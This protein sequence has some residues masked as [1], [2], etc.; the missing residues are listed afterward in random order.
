[1]LR[2]QQIMNR[3]A[4]ELNDELD[5]YIT[6]F[7]GC[8]FWRI[9]EG[10]LIVNKTFKRIVSIIADYNLTTVDFVLDNVYELPESSEFMMQLLARLAFQYG[11]KGG[12][13]I[14]NRSMV[15]CYLLYYITTIEGDL[16][17]TDI[18]KDSANSELM[19]KKESL[20]QSIKHAIGV[21]EYPY[22]VKGNS[23]AM[24]LMAIVSGKP[25]HETMR[26][27]AEYK[28]LM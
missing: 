6:T 14:L 13:S 19:Y 12:E 9:K 24:G 21:S 25:I 8:D 2:E 17:A 5:D 20:W 15:L 22:K 16:K 28:D 4:S 3:I 27:I 1:M 7:N 23:R 10:E 26:Y 11:E 18:L